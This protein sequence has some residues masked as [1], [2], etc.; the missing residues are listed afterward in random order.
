MSFSLKISIHAAPGAKTTQLAGTHEHALR[1]RLAAPPVDGK[2]NSALLAWA[3]KT[4]GV[5][6]KQV[7]LLHGAASRQKVIQID[8]P[9]EAQW[10]AACEQLQRLQQV[11]SN[12]K[13]S[14]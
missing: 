10:Q 8:F 6:K 5:A 1:L 11:S 4:F 14:P 2:A 12:Q 9:S 3:A 13:A 7:E